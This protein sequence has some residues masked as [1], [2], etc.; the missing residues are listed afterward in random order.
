M[1]ENG[2][3]PCQFAIDEKWQRALAGSAIVL[4]VFAAYWSSL[5]VPFF[6]DDSAA[7]VENPTIWRLQSLDAVFSPP[8]DGSG[9]TG[10]P[11]VNL[12]LALNY[13]WGGTTAR[14]YHLFNLLLHACTCLILFG[15]VRRT[16]RQPVLGAP[17]GKAAT[18]LAFAA[19]LL[20][21]VHPLQTESV[22]CVIQRTELLV[23]CFY[24]LTLYCFVRSAEPG[25]SPW[26]STATVAACLC[27]MASKEVMVSAPLIVLFYDRTF[28]AGT[29]REA[30]GRRRGLYLGLIATWLLLGALL[31][32][33]GGSRG[34]AAG[35]GLGIAWWSYALKQCEAILLYVRLGF[36]PHPL[37]LDYGTEVVTNPIDVAPEAAVLALLVAGTLV[38]LWRRP[39]LGFAGLWFF[40][41]LAPSSSVVPLVTQ[42]M[43]EHRM[44]LP[45]AAMLVA[46]II[47]THVLIGRRGLLGALGV[48]AGFGVLTAQRQGA[49]ASELSIWTDTLAKSPRTARVQVNL[50]NALKALGRY[51]EALAHYQSAL[52]LNPTLPEAL[53]DVGSALIL[54]GRTAEAKAPCE[55]ALRLKPNFA[56]AHTNLGSA[57]CA[58]GRFDEAKRQFEAALVQKPRLAAA[59]S[60]LA[61]V[62]IV[63]GQFQE[64]MRHCEMAIRDD[65][66]LPDAYYNLGVALLRTGHPAD[67]VANFE[68][69][70]RLRPNYPEA[71]CDLATALIQQGRTN[72][73]AGHY[74]AAVRLR[75]DYFEAHSNFGT[76]LFRLGRPIDAI[77][78][79][80]EAIRRNPAFA[81]AHYNLAAVLSQLGQVPEAIAEYE[82]ALRLQPDR[83]DARSNLEQLRATQAA[84]SAADRKVPH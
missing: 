82:E 62:L 30:W 80:R 38:A 10:R 17:I 25:S 23:G 52:Q 46:L 37:V 56:E 34:T 59:H 74:E 66:N 16:L 61:G 27:G 19:A 75:P 55:A 41:I 76:A 21:A 11:L 31:V 9:V 40:A 18:S 72:Q 49:Y 81:E 4:A 3:R 70:L 14:G 6:F 8:H 20:W 33:V 22:T 1:K 64:A 83:A 32:S 2:S 43:A 42:T 45:L 26:W 78:Q 68:N 5:S 53:C 44:Y 63:S 58:L 12:T 77:A 84:T 73:A 28:V 54:L 48:A 13:S 7:I 60:D 57:L 69:A 51:N 71:H 50:G 35:F 15:L 39:V 79:Y 65:P 29:F 24:L 67:S 47:V 36:W